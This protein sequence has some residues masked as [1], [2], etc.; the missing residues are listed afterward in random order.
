MNSYKENVEKLIYDLHQYRD[1]T[2]LDDMIIDVAK[3]CANGLE[4]KELYDLFG[5]LVDTKL[6][7]GQLSKNAV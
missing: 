4:E 7:F 5:F 1:F 6:V 2:N 3:E